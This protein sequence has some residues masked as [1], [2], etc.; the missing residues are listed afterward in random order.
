MGSGTA[1][2]V[3][4]IQDLFRKHN[5][6]I[7]HFWAQLQRRWRF[8]VLLHA[9][10]RRKRSGVSSAVLLEIVVAMPILLVATVQGFFASQFQRMVT[11]SQWA[12]HRFRQ[13][14]RFHWR[15]V[16]Y[17]FHKEIADDERRSNLTPQRPTAL[18]L[19]DTTL[20]K[21]GRHIEGVSWVFDHVSKTLVMGYKLLALSWFNGS[22]A[23]FLDF[24]LVAEK[25]LTWKRNHG[26][27]RKAR[28]KTSPG[29]V[30]QAE[31]RQDKIT[32]GCE[33]LVRAVEQGFVPDFVLCDTWFTCARLINQVRSLGQGT[34]HF[35]GM[36]KDGR[37]KLLYA[38]AEFT[39]HEL[40]HHLLSQL[41][42][43]SRFRSRYIVVDCIIPQV[44]NVRIFFSR[45]HGRRKWVA[46]ITTQ[47]NLSYIKAI[48][49]YAIRWTIEVGFKEA[50]SL[51]GLGRCQANDLDCQMAHATTVF[52]AHAML[53]NWKFHEEYQSLGILY[54]E[55]EHQY[56][57]L[58]TL[59]KL[60]LLF[61][62]LM[63]QIAAQLGGINQVTVEQLLNSAEYA[64]FKVI[65]QQSLLLGARNA[66]GDL[67]PAE[68]A[69]N[70]LSA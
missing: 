22:Y 7:D 70:A 42:R 50:K 3:R 32:L 60:L 31:L 15:R 47:R 19:D 45:F 59:D 64:Q 38:G 1:T 5:T 52:M 36:I 41:H 27:F 18:I 57:Q 39:L 9:G 25:A 10:G 68:A 14:A 34:V 67:L 2:H 49:T 63:Q 55:I 37:R 30:R 33:M 43:C 48:E 4:E 46:L 28:E 12:V 35:L 51:L 11:A 62:A 6:D 24:S 53:V 29:A 26:S 17:A 21:T 66:T 23:R 58:L 69:N 61:E 54:A 65:L 44:G 16:L 20:A 13:D 40:R 8:A 56:T